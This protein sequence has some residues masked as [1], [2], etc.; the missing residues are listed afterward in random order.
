MTASEAHHDSPGPSRLIDAHQHFWDLANPSHQWPDASLPAIHRS[1][2]PPD[3][4]AETQGLP[5]AGTVLVQAQPDDADTDW[6]L[7]LAAAQ[8]LVLAV[9]GW[10]D[11][12]DPRAPQRIAELAR[13]P[14]MRGLRPMLQAIDDTD[15][16]LRSEIAPGIEAMIRHG[17]RFD[18][19]VQPRHLPTLAC[20]AAR[21][22]EL[23]I[24]VDH[25]AKPFIA[26]AALDPWR[27]GIA[28]LAALPNVHCKLSGLRNEMAPGQGIDALRPYV[29]QLTATF[30]DR[31]MWGSDWPVLLD[32]GTR[33]GDWID[34]AERLAAPPTDAARAML[35]AGAAARFYGLAELLA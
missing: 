5:L 23:P 32:T 24:V 4:V 33:Y 6:M 29:D 1:F 19:L 20:F 22:P 2:L 10:V 34:E 16:M 9:V 3:L 15:W 25:G 30:G 14:K 11:L 35:F 21:W 31:L 18:A 7:D 27:D 26:R 13:H 12:A 17:L 28:A 8:D